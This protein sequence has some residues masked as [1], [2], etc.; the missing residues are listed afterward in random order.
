MTDRDYASE[1][2]E[3]AAGCRVL[4]A[5]DLAP[6]IL[7]HISL[8]VDDDRIL[9]RC[10]G[11]QERGLA[12][13][14]ADDIRLVTL[15][16][17]GAVEGELADGYGVPH[18]FP[19]HA[20]ILRLRP[21]VSCVVHAHPREVVTA[22]LAG[23]EI[24]PIVG[25]FDIPGAALARQG[26]PVY[27]RGVLIHDS[28][29]GRDVARS[30]GDRSALVMRGHGLTTVGVTVA[31]SVLRAAAVHQIATMSLQIKAAGGTP[32]P[33]AAADLAQLPD[34]GEGLNLSA[35]WRHEL[36]RTQRSD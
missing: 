11:P 25:A 7:G 29:L 6:G 27:P 23:L 36:S 5:R 10:R 35:A 26:V 21:D 15:D 13:T 17:V 1:R 22:D 30:L 19:L 3:V 32:A 33:L 31:E 14:T 28:D 16:G 20:E 12:S 18:E 4:A 24:M 34:L 8:R 9:I 2:A